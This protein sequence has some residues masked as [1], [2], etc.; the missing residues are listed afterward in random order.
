MKIYEAP[1]VY[2]GR[3]TLFLAGGISGCPDWQSEA[4]KEFEDLDDD[5]KIANPRRKDFD[6]TDEKVSEKQIK[7]EHDALSH[8]NLIL[9]W[10][11]KETVCPITLYELGYWLGFGHVMLFI[12]VHP[13]YSRRF[14][15]EQQLKHFAGRYKPKYDLKEICEDAKNI[16]KEREYA[17]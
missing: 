9:F 10:F 1:N 15:I 8:S 2:D 12:G 5:C 13:E 7:W 3:Y 16:M 14:D 11:P 6:I 4:L 17:H